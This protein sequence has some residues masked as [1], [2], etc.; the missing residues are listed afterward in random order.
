MVIVG[1]GSDYTPGATQYYELSLFGKS[2][3]ESTKICQS[4]FKLYLI[5]K[6]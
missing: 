4:N 6:I 3:L 1:D 5:N 2:T